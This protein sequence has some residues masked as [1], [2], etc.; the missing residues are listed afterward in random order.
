M[1]FE[2]SE[3]EIVRVVRRREGYTLIKALWKERVSRGIMV[4]AVL[5]LSV[6]FVFSSIDKYDGWDSVFI[7]I[8]MLLWLLFAKRIGRKCKKDGVNLLRDFKI[9]IED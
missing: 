7:G 5:S 1:L 2:L 6:A 8:G 9:L 4:L 3:E